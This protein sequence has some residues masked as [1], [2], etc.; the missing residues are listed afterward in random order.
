MFFVQPLAESC[1]PKNFIHYCLVDDSF[2]MTVDARTDSR[3]NRFI[4]ESFSLAFLGQV[5]QK[6]HIRFLKVR[7]LWLNSYIE[8]Y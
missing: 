1:T 2:A 8:K 6:S 5:R 4:F 3:I 7:N